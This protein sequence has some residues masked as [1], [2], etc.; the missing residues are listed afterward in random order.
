MKIGSE[1]GKATS[2]RELSLISR[3]SAVNHELTEVFVALGSNLGNRHA[4]LQQSV[5]FLAADPAIFELTLSNIYST[6]P[7]GFTAQPLFL[8]AVCR[9]YTSYK[10]NQLLNLTQ[11]IERW[12]GKQQIVRN[13]P[14]LI[15]LDILLFGQERHQEARLT[16][17]HPRWQERLFVLLPL[18]NLVK[19]IKIPSGKPPYTPVLFSIEEHL[20]TFTNPH[21]E[22]VTLWQN[23]DR[24]RIDI[25]HSSSN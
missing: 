23:G 6:T 20:R 4:Y 11:A 15:D 12:L 25:V 19:E 13:G 24:D 5:A 1:S 21:Q 8:N 17:P 22:Q 9:F 10:A 18:S 14:R 3:I 7:V 2:Y 16:I